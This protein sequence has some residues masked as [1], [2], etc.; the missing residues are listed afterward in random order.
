MAKIS[1]TI[2]APITFPANFCVLT[3][4]SSKVFKMM[5]VEE[6][7]KMTPKNRLFILPQSINC[8]MK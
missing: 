8:P 1:C 5:V 7:D 3:P 2:K 6:M 4:N